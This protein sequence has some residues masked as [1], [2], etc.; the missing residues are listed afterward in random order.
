MAAP[1]Q[2][3]RPAVARSPPG[4]VGTR[5]VGGAS[6]RQLRSRQSSTAAA[7]AQA[8]RLVTTRH[9]PG[10][11]GTRAVG[12]ALRRQ[13]TWPV[14]STG[15]EP[16]RDAWRVTARR[17]AAVAPGRPS[18]RRPPACRRFPLPSGIPVPCLPRPGWPPGKVEACP[19]P[20]R[21]LLARRL[22]P[23]SAQTRLVR[24][25][26]HPRGSQLSWSACAVICSCLAN[27]GHGK[28]SHRR[29]RRSR[30]PGKGDPGPGRRPR[31]CRPCGAPGRGSKRTR[32]V[33]RS[34]GLGGGGH[35]Q[36]RREP[37]R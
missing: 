25:R 27:G 20:A 26:P 16:R 6:C 24:A 29:A 15:A 8:T 14:S 36:R 11:V 1:A 9:S 21:G 18:G 4:L 34:W 5:V 13:P 37:G 19:L 22:A 33:A 7:P 23:P 35:R 31:V 2:A 30:R 3:T 17:R 28:S 12:G 32:P 10:P